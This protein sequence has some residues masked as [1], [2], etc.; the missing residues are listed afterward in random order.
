M[1][2]APF[3]YTRPANL[4]AALA[5]IADGALPLA[6]GQSLLQAMRLR[7]AEPA[8]V[9]DLNAVAELSRGHHWQ[10]ST[11]TIGALATHASIVAADDIAQEMPWLCA[12]ARALGDVQVRNLGTIL[13]N[14]CWADPR[15]NMLIALL[16]SD[17]IVV[18]RHPAESGE[19]RIAIEHFVTGFREHALD[20][21][22][23][24]ALE[25]PRRTAHGAYLEF[26]RQRQDLALVNVCVVRGERHARVAIGGIHR[27][28]VRAVAFEE[29]LAARPLH[30]LPSAT[31]LAGLLDGLD[32]VP[33][34]DAHSTPGYKCELA[35]V[36]VMRALRAIAE[37]AR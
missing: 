15:A 34:E 2:P 5:A 28:P 13:G 23:A 21:A 26:S 33:I 16:A 27:T 10:A 9:V 29:L 32:L 36:L 4:H 25:V 35:R 30:A 12:A 24:V 37:L 14:V 11:L 3:S 8:A 22:L 31:E 7:S 6:G 18:A 1:R 17:A 20:G 19:R